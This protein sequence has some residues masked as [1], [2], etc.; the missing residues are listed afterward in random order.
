M[1]AALS[2]KVQTTGVRKLFCSAFCFLTTKIDYAN[3]IRHIEAVRS[4]IEDSY[5]CFQAVVK[6]QFSVMQYR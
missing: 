6:L 5:H 3:R 1:I 4:D 2:P